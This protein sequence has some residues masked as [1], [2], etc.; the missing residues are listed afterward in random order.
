M[1]S[2]TIY[3]KVDIQIRKNVITTYNRKTLT[4]YQVYFG[5]LLVRR[6]CQIVLLISKVSC[7]GSRDMWS[8]GH[9]MKIREYR[10]Y[11]LKNWVQHGGLKAL[12]QAWGWLK[13]ECSTYYMKCWGHPDAHLV[14]SLIYRNTFVSVAGLLREKLKWN[15]G[16]LI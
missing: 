15:D 12:T 13:C 5:G 2:D 6:K 4:R 16:H 14:F 8:V 11:C 7:K 10:K 1:L 3:F 9:C